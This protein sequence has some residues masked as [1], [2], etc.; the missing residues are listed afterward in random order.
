MGKA[1]GTGRNKTETTVMDAGNEQWEERRDTLTTRH[2]S[3]CPWRR[4]IATTNVSCALALAKNPGQGG[5][6]PSTAEAA[7]PVEMALTRLNC[8]CTRA[9]T[10]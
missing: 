6:I 2:P 8:A 3:I 1:G 10:A 4:S 7:L 5:E 9:A